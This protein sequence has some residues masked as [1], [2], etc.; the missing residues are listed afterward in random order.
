M[1]T[2]CIYFLPAIALSPGIPVRDYLRRNGLAK[3]R[4]KRAHV[5]PA[6]GGNNAREP[7]TNVEIVFAGAFAT[8]KPGLGEISRQ[9]LENELAKIRP[10]LLRCRVE[11]LRRFCGCRTTINGK[12][13]AVT[14]N[15]GFVEF[16][17]L[18]G[19][20]RRRM[21][22]KCLLT[23]RSTFLVWHLKSLK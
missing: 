13:T 11:L 18:S 14:R 21:M 17:V 5:F 12:E 2:L 9:L 16:A 23:W 8:D 4:L 10:M 1:Q 20:W 6:S 15:L 22:F 3:L 7:G 19:L